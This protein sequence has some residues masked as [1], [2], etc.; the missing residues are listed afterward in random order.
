MDTSPRS[1]ENLPSVGIV[2][3]WGMA[4]LPNRPRLPSGERA[5]AVNGRVEIAS[6]LSVNR[7]VRA[8]IFT[9]TI[10]PGPPSI[11][12]DAQYALLR[13]CDA[14]LDTIPPVP[15]GGAARD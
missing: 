5:S 15:G 13:G 10:L 8:E 12:V 6:P 14:E 11:L 3:L 7:L 9:V 1:G 4:S 2:Q